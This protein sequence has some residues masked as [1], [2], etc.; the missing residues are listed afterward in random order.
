LV[1]VRDGGVK[2]ISQFGIVLFRCRDKRR[3]ALAFHRETLTASI[4]NPY[5]N[6]PKTRSAQ[7]IPASLNTL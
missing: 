7:C 5:L 6:G 4:G 1:Q 3:L 2:E